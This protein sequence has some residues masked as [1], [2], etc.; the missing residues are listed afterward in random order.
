MPS[1]RSLGTLALL[2]V[3]AAC[4]ATPSGDG[5]AP[6]LPELQPLETTESATYAVSFAATGGRP[7]LSYALD[8]LPPGFTFYT[9][10]GQ[11]QGPAKTQGVYPLTVQVKDAAGLTDTREYSLLVD[12]APAVLTATLPAA[13]QGQPY[14][15]QLEATGGR[16]PWLWSLVGGT[17]PAGL[18]LS[19]DGQLQGTPQEAGS[20]VPQVRVREGNGATADRLYGLEVRSGPLDT[21]GGTDGGTGVAF[22]AANWNLNWFGSPDAG[23]SD[24][25]K[26]LA[27]VQQVMATV[28]ADVWGLEEVADVTQFNALV[29]RMPGYAGFVANDPSIPSGSSNYSPTEQ[30]PALLF[31]SSLVSV[32]EK[33]LMPVASGDLYSFGG[34]PPL[35]AKLRI[36]HGGSSVDLTVIVLHMKAFADTD[37]YSRRLQASGV[38]KNYLDTQY[39]GQP[40]LVVGDWN[41]DVDVSITKDSTSG[42]YLPSPY[43]NFVD[44]SADYTFLTQPLSLQHKRSTVSNTEFIDH[45]LATPLL[46][47]GYVSNSTQVFVP[48]YI[49]DYK[50]TTTDHYPVL[51][52]FSFSAPSGP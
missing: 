27:N 42:G 5:T 35:Q 44:D 16:S 18:S 38:L 39:K 8:P 28:D 40:V 25:P 23:P 7:P 36:T 17:L 24:E 9:T 6:A 37:S 43:Q 22:S 26:Q 4:N 3:L 20:F 29:Q 34:R 13:T 48:S 46:L 19:T 50:N 32:L 1:I 11:L 15:V 49:T 33:K 31:R 45:Q 2:V 10:T 41:D 21:D 47:Q 12:A 52:R 14:A 51:S 30:K